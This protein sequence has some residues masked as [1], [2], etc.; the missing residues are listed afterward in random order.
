[1]KFQFLFKI[2]INSISYDSQI[3]LGR[4]ELSMLPFLPDNH[5]LVSSLIFF[6]FLFTL[7]FV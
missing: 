1:M 7:F 4:F 3:S 2:H 6:F 5:C